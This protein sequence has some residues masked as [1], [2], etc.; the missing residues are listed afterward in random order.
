[1]GT[2]STGHRVPP[3]RWAVVDGC[4]APVWVEL[5]AGAHASDPLM[6]AVA[7]FVASGFERVDRVARALHLDASL[8]ES[9]L[10]H[11]AIAGA[12]IVD[13]EGRWRA[14]DAN[15]DAATGAAEEVDVRE[16]WVAWDPTTN[17]AL[18]MIWVA[19]W[20]PR[21][22]LVD[23]RPTDGTNPTDLRVSSWRPRDVKG[24]DLQRELLVLTRRDD[25]TLFE[26]VADRARP[27]DTAVLRRLRRRDRGT[28]RGPLWVRFGFRPP[29]GHVVY[30]PVCV[31]SD[32]APWS[33]DPK[34]W[35]GL[36]NRADDAG[37][38]ELHRLEDLERFEL[39]DDLLREHGYR[40]IADLRRAA[41]DE[42]KRRLVGLTGR[43]RWGTTEAEVE[44]ALFGRRV[45]QM[46]QQGARAEMQPF[47]TVLETALTEAGGWAL[48]FLQQLHTAG[49][50][51]RPPAGTLLETLGP[52][53]RLLTHRP[54]TPTRLA[55]LVSQLEGA[56]DSLGLRLAALGLALTHHDGARRAFDTVWAEEPAWFELADRANA[57]RN[58]VVHVTTPE[59]SLNADAFAS[60]VLHVVRGLLTLD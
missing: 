50:P 1:M 7:D 8:V 18:P 11:L 32:D 36:L 46:T 21:R 27:L 48:P 41:R 56:L 16:G 28:C 23:T 12:V 59:S 55:A 47:V 35:Q 57:L 26:P 13:A 37:R 49:T 40:D 43:E 22:D 60:D 17:Q 4:Y 14:A 3:E 58:Q 2:L 15:A 53:G 54:P 30:R 31:A 25:L 34:G 51:L 29:D 45:A 20:T 6:R 39:P 10:A 24:D 33:L 9:A 38:G 5:E 52:T 44:R 19:S 42:A